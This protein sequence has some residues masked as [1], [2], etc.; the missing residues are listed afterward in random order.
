M[1]EQIL[2]TSFDVSAAG[3]TDATA[4]CVLQTKAGSYPDLTLA[5]TPV[6]VEPAAFLSTAKPS[7]AAAVAE[8]GKAGYTAGVPA[9][10]PAGPGVEVGWLSGNG[11]LLVLRYRCR[12]GSDESA[13]SDK[14]VALAKKIDRD[15]V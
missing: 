9:V 8:L 4:T 6:N 15:G 10:E 5:V 3:A 11:R 14:L 2:G 12:P 7:G 1:I 13:L